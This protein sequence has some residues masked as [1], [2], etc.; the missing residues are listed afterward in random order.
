MS[1]ITS[2]IFSCK[3]LCF[4]CDPMTLIL[5]PQNQNPL[6]AGCFT[7][8]HSLRIHYS[9]GGEWWW[10]VKDFQEAMGTLILHWLGRHF[11]R[12]SLL[13]FYNYL[14]FGS[15]SKTLKELISGELVICK[16][17]SVSEKGV[18]FASDLVLVHSDLITD[19]V[20][21]SLP[22]IC[23]YDHLV[24]IKRMSFLTWQ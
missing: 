5:R 3:C 1:L 13:L 18:L 10:G 21:V 19:L 23:H 15:L 9:R 7:V 24:N 11:S 20:H 22:L 4:Y 17:L 14:A 8:T 6:A 12:N 2:K 16:V